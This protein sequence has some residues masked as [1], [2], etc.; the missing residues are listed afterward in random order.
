[1]IKL[2]Y[3]LS[4]KEKIKISPYP[5][6]KSFGFTIIDDTDGCRLE[7]I[8]PIYD[9]LSEL[10][11]KTTKTVWV[12]R[13]KEKNLGIWDEGDTLEREDYVNY[14]KILQKRGFEIALHNISSKSNKREEIINGLEKFKEIF[15]DY[16]KINV[17]HEKNKENLYFKFA[18]SGDL[19]PKTF[20]RQFL[21]KINS[22]FGKL[23]K[24]IK[25]ASNYNDKNFNDFLGEIKGSEYFWGDICKDKIK[26]VRTNIFYRDLNTLKC[27]PRIPYSTEQTPYVNYWFDSSN[28]QDADA[29]EKI[30]NSSNINRL[31]KE[32]GCCILYT[33]FAKGFSIVKKGRV[34]LDERIKQRLIEISSS[35]DGWY[36]P[37]G[38]MLD[39]I[40]SFKKIRIFLFRN[41]IILKNENSFSI[42]D[43]TLWTEPHEKYYQLGG[44]TFISDDMGRIVIPL[45]KNDEIFVLWKKCAINDIKKEFWMN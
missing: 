11:L 27:N 41:G 36:A 45:L 43:I 42:K 25:K 35:S 8:Q 40:L 21:I 6:G 29:F 9:F 10:Q 26:Y 15:G 19:M 16:P 20:R 28:G 31:K 14:L 23:R 38:E 18:C 13:P 22:I 39:R 5:A 24:L 4:N 30:L 32:K 34:T 17:H 2:S 12:W 33:H 44:Q 1:M 3:L 37:V 7:M